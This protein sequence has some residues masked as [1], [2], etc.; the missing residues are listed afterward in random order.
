MEVPLLDLK[1]QYEDIQEEILLA[2]KEIF[3]SQRFILGPKVEELEKRIAGY[4]QCDY[5]VG[6]SSGTD[7][8]LISLMTEGIGI[9]DLVVTTPYTF[10]ATVGAV[11]RVGAR[12]VF[13]DIDK[14][15][16]NMDPEGLDLALSHVDEEEKSRVKAI[17][18]VHL[19]GQC[20]D[21]V[22]ILNVA[23]EHDLSVIEDA[24]QAIGAEYE[25]AD[26]EIKRAGS[27]GHY[28]CFSFYPTK[29]LGAF[30]EAG[31][32]TT[33]DRV[34]YNNLKTMRNHGDVARYDHSFIGGNF[35]LDAL[36]A[37]ILLVK[38]KYLDEWIRKRRENASLYWTLFREEGLE[39]IL[40]P[41]EMEKR[42]VYNQFVIK[43]RDRRD[44]LKKYLAEKG[45]GCE[46]F[47]PVPLHMQACF[48]YLGYKSENF[49][50]SVE[51][52]KKTLGLP[53]YP[54]LRPE[55]I[56][57]VVDMIREFLRQR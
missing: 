13:V 24:A 5:A 50:V 21:M 57:Y 39:W 20:A 51:A 1:E 33:N 49:P 25:F 44:E 32:V 3:D 31:M 26:G 19:F 56:Y 8:L 12:P 28:G 23:E 10:F 2:T 15:T 14:S 7:A 34:V 27:M 37:A 38:L 9:G 16:Y 17:I 30:G 4:C 55:Q 42:H 18:P 47:Y 48:E 29:N 45:V 54:E 36:Q 6:V 46:V 41:E 52:A 22:R 53:I 43:I 35:R 11:A 40:L